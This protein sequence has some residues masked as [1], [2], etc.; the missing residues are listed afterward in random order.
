MLFVCHTESGK[1]SGNFTMLGEWSLLSVCV[2]VTIISITVGIFPLLVS[3]AALLELS[4]YLSC[5]TNS[6]SSCCC[7][8]AV[9]EH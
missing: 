9:S 2:F 6:Y 1:K 3:S 7:Y 5:L 4:D 8:Y